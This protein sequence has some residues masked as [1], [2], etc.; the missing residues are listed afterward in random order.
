MFEQVFSASLAFKR[1]LAKVSRVGSGS[2]CRSF[3]GPFVLWSEENTEA[4]PHQMPELRHFVI[5]VSESQKT[6][7]ST[8]A[9]AR[10]KTSPLWNGRTERVETRLNDLQ[11]ALAIGDLK[12]VSLH[13]WREAWEMHSLFHTS[14][15]PFTYWKGQTVEVL[16]WLTP[17]V[18]ES[19]QAPI[20]TLDAGPNVHVTVLASRY[21]EWRERLVARFGAKGF[22]EDRPGLGASFA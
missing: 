8:E 11:A 6:V 17:F 13:A 19:E 10:V 15:E 9:H 21:E 2:S 12:S 5:L 7:S 14:V 20:V 22:L 18:Y 3:E 4:V 16:N 1:E